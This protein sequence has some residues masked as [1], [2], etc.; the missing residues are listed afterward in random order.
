MA[1]KPDWVNP[2]ILLSG[3]ISESQK[4]YERQL[5]KESKRKNQRETAKDNILSGFKC[6]GYKC[7][8]KKVWETNDIKEAKKFALEEGW[9]FGKK[10]YYCPKCANK[11]RR[12]NRLKYNPPGTEIP[13]V[14]PL[15]TQSIFKN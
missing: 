14:N 12:K 1:A 7:N 4:E 3:T 10:N 5:E 6:S 2:D 9:S 8:Q 11:K 15:F 13:N